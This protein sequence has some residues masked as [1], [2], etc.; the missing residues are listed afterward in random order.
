MLGL[1]WGERASQHGGNVNLEDAVVT[2]VV[3]LCC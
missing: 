3:A 2:D 1:T